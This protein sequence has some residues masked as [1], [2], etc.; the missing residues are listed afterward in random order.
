[1]DMAILKDSSQRQ[2]ECRSLYRTLNVTNKETIEET[3]I[4]NEFLST[5][6]SYV[7]RNKYPLSQK[8]SFCLVLSSCFFLIPACYA[9]FYGFYIHFLISLVTSLV[10]INYWR[11][12][13][14]GWRASLDLIVAKLSF[15]IYFGTGFLNI[16][17]T[18]TMFIAWPV[19][20]GIIICYLF[21]NKMWDKDCFTWVFY[22]MSFHLFVAI[23]KFIVLNSLFE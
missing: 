3:E 21:S 12:A 22:H 16:K 13:I 7:R 6:K 14:P 20:G 17:D 9:F 11:L 18:K 23:G 10:S 15:V 2:S 19:C 1:M 4:D 5:N 8:D